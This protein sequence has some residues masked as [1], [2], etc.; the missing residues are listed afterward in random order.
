M[1]KVIKIGVC[2]NK[3]DKIS[4]L[5][6]VSAIKGKGLLNDRN[7]KENNHQRTQ[8]TLIEIENI[9]YYNKISKTNISPIDFRRNIITEGIKL[10]ELLGKEFF[11]GQI[12]VKC[13]DLCRPC[14]YLQKKL[15]QK[16]LVKE[17]IDKAGLRCEI[18]SSGKISVGD[19]IK[20]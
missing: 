4:S 17:L 15:G 18:L 9:N 6:Q 10:N 11:I 13:H 20:N 14:N 8:V 12:K 1:A 16:N 7:F 3:G 2:K 19:I 5:D